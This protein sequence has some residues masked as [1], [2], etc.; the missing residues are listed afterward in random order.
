MNSRT[1]LS[2]L[3]LITIVGGTIGAI[4]LGIDLGAVV[5]LV[6]FL[7]SLIAGIFLA[8]FS[9]VL[10][11]LEKISNNVDLLTKEKNDN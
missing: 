3:S 5:G 1:S 10:L 8:A 9:D 6:A 4:I 7:S 11:Y 2:I